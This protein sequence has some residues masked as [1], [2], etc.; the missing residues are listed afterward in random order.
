MS[1]QYVYIVIQPL[2]FGVRKETLHINTAQEADIDDMTLQI[3]LVMII[4]V[5]DPICEGHCTVKRLKHIRIG[6]L[7]NIE[8]NLLHLLEVLVDVVVLSPLQHLAEGIISLVH[9]I[10]L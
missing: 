10:L 2:L 4:S 9:I 3:L 6:N 5:E 7:V 1:Y 8:A